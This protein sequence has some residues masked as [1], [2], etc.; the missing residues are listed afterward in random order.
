LGV[1]EDYID[2]LVRYLTLFS[3]GE[4]SGSGRA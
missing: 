2:P 3:G 1:F 4:N